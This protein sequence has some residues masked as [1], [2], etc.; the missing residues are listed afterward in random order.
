M[1]SDCVR[2]A[3]RTLSLPAEYCENLSSL[4]AVVSWQGA[5]RNSSPRGKKIIAGTVNNNPQ[6][7][8]MGK[9]FQHW[10]YKILLTSHEQAKWGESGKDD[11]YLPFNSGLR[12]QEWNRAKDVI[13][14]VMYIIACVGSQEGPEHYLIWAAPVTPEETETRKG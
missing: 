5:H 1:S 13:N 9:H 12:R 11:F 3:S 8:Q 14:M 4:F 2:E 7:I 6:I 10:L